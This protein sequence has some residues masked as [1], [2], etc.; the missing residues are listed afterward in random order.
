MNEP[1]KEAPN[2]ADRERVVERFG[3]HDPGP[4]LNR[5]ANGTLRPSDDAIALHSWNTLAEAFRDHRLQERDR[6]TDGV[7]RFLAIAD[8]SKK[9][10]LSLEAVLYTMA[11]V[12]RGEST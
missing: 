8:E 9:G 7:A 11:R 4:L 12:I 2:R 1:T 10:W 5:W 6:I 3:D